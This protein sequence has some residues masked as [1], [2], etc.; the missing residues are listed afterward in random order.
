[1][2]LINMIVDGKP[3]LGI[4][5]EKGVV[6]ASTVRPGSYPKLT[7]SKTTLPSACSG[8]TASGAFCISTGISK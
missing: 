7:W 8:V 5:T 2:K 3:R 6:D 4:L 1:M